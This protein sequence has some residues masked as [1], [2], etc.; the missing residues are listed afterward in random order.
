MA[1]KISWTPRAIRDR[2][3]ILEYW[4]NRNKSKTYSRK[5]YQE[6]SS[7]IKLVAANPELGKSTEFSSVRMIVVDN[8][9]IYYS[10]DKKGIEIGAICYPRRNPSKFKL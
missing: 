9:L 10:I 1:K 3:E 5:L 6:F 4:S 7:N 2:F 8:Y